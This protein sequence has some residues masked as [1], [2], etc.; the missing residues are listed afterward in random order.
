MSW[1]FYTY[2]LS[3]FGLCGFVRLLCLWAAPIVVVAKA[4]HFYSL[5]H[6]VSSSAHRPWCP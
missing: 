6:I 3:L 2:R 1:I 5:C 4:A